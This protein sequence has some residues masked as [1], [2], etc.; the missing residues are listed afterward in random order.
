MAIPLSP[1]EQARIDAYWGGAP[2][3]SAAAPAMSAAPDPAV[4]TYWGAPPPAAPEM[5]PAGPPPPPP[6]ASPPPP[7]PYQPNPGLPGYQPNPGATPEVAAP[8]P[9][10]SPGLS[11][12]DFKVG[13]ELSA[14]PPQIAQQEAI[15]QASL[16]GPTAAD[17]AALAD[18]NARLAATKTAA[19]PAGRGAPANPDPFGIGAAQRAQLGA[20]DARM[21]AM[22][23]AA[24][25]EQD[26][27]VMHAEHA[28][29][30]SRMQ[31]EDAA[32][33]RAEQEYAAKHFD[34]QM[35]EIGRQ[36]DDVRTR[37]VDP[38]KAIH[39]S[40]ALG[41]ISVLGGMVSGFY[42]GLTNGQENA[43]IKDLHMQMDRAVAEQE[44]QIRDEKFVL[45]EGANM[46]H[47][48][49]QAQKDDALAKMQFRNLMY[50][51]AKN[52]MAAEAER[53][54]TDIAKANAD[55]GIELVRGEQARLQEQ[56][57]RQ[58]AAQS[59]AAASAAH[60]QRKEVQKAMLEQ[61]DRGIA[62]GMAPGQA[63]DWARHVVGLAYAPGIPNP[64]PSA[65][66]SG[67]A[68]PLSVVPKT[69]QSEAAK[70][71]QAHSTAES[72]IRALDG[73]FANWRSVGV[74]S[75]RQMD[76]IKATISGVYKSALGPGMSSDKD[77]ETFIE[78]NIP[79]LG[80]S[81]E[82]LA[83][84]QRNIASTIRGKVA[85]PILDSHAKGWRQPTAQEADA[86]LGAKPVR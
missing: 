11:A 83:M 68:D 81:A 10:A 19:P 6:Q 50:E 66:A 56:I 57:A 75:P 72:G 17:N 41:A 1:E 8:P 14:A 73:Q 64:R 4:A 15:R 62:S 58:K 60:S 22:G 28:A 47:Q 35:T 48:Q 54:G 9:P 63:V 43:F 52:E 34:E 55:A 39:D 44:R 51:A 21:G 2:Q 82:T 80:D 23:R 40:P 26:R 25:A 84:K 16:G 29:N 79:K 53:N 37:K 46:L 59:A 31:E 36:L 33:A 78:P 24:T 67:G 65:A 20:Y 42:Q 7:A 76:S 49:R 38:L 3:S 77:F 86:A 13:A 85:T 5:P 61:Y 69:L 45:D 30:L 32:I 18:L 27:D 12:S 70:E 71:L 74:T